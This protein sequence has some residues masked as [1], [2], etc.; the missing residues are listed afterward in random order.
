[1]VYEM[2]TTIKDITLLVLS[3]ECLYRYIVKMNP[4]DLYIYYFPTKIIDDKPLD[5]SLQNKYDDL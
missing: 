2:Y 3:I 5:K 4:L 1:M